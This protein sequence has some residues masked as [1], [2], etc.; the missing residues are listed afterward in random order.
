MHAHE[1]LILFAHPR[2]GSSSLCRILKLH[3][4]LRVLEEPF[5]EGF[6]R[7]GET[8]IDYLRAI[9]DIPSLDHQLAQIFAT[10]NGLKMLNYQLPDAL[11]THILRHPD[12][13]VVFLRRTNLLQAVVSVMLAHQTQLWHRWDTTMPLADHYQHL[14]PLD[15][16][17]VQDRIQALAGHLDHCESILAQ[18]PADTWFKLTY[19]EVYGIPMEQQTVQLAR[20]WRFLDLPPLPADRV[21]YYL[22]QDAVKLNSPATYALLPNADEVHERCGSDHTGWLYT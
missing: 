12:H 9:S 10:Y 3:P 4:A 1:R 21:Q 19:E 11:T 17:E 16:A 14:Q 18:R 22:S 20:L 13:R 15:I 5:N 8:K 2:S 6:V 7:W